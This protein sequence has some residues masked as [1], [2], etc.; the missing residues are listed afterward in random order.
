MRRL[1]DGRLAIGA[2]TTYAELLGLARAPLRAARRRVAAASATSRSATGARSAGR[3]PTPIPPRTCRPACWPWT[4]ELVPA[5]RAANGRSRST[6]SCR[7][8]SAP[9]CGRTRS[10]PRSACPGRATTPG[11]PTPSLENPAS[12]YA[13]VGVAAVV[14]AGGGGASVGQCRPDRGRRGGVSSSRRSNR[15]CGSDGS[16][17]GYRGGRRARHRRRDRQRRHPRR[18][19]TIERAWRSSTPVAR[20][21]PRSPARLT[22]TSSHACASSRSLLVGAR[23]GGWWRGPDP[24]PDGRR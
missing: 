10:S 7:V 4:A 19:A 23:P 9:A 14:F 12:G 5:R 22:R 16:P 20:S 17:A 21:R 1:D 18:I 24:R 6:V 13:I 8:R 2:L 3:S 15:R 11:R